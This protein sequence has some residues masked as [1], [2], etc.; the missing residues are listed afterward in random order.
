MINQRIAMLPGA[1]FGTRMGEYTKSTPKPLL[2]VKGVPL[3]FYSL[4]L[5]SISFLLGS[6]YGLGSGA[7][8]RRGYGWNRT[9][10][11]ARVTCMA[12]WN[13]PYR[14]SRPNGCDPGG[15][16]TISESTSGS[17]HSWRPGFVGPRGKVFS[18][19]PDAE[20]FARRGRRLREIQA[21]DRLSASLRGN[22][23]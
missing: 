20:V 23:A 9:Q 6:L 14:N 11:L 5:L 13:T 7:G 4:F 21:F 17:P 15:S 1:G 12:K 22:R 16:F 2:P 8:Q 18:F 3:L 10:G 19:E